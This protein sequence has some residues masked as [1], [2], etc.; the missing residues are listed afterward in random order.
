MKNRMNN[1]ITRIRK[2]GALAISVFPWT[3]WENNPPPNL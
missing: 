1:K 3:D 2:E